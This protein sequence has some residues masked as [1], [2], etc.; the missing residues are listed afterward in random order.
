MHTVQQSAQVATHV[1]AVVA[2]EVESM[3]AHLCEDE[4]AY[5]GISHNVL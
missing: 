2:R 5:H 4:L 3:S 1:I